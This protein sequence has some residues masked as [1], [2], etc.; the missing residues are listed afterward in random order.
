[1]LGVSLQNFT[2]L[3][4]SA[5]FLRPFIWPVAILLRIRQR[6]SFKCCENLGENVTETLEMIRQA[7]G[8]EGM[9]RTWKVQT[10]QDRKKRRDI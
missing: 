10:R 8:E 7:F 4:G 9:S 1:M 3:G 2:Q 6:N 5:D